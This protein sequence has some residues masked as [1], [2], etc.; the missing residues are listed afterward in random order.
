MLEQMRR[1]TSGAVMMFRT[2][3][4]ALNALNIFPMMWKIGAPQ[5]VKA[6]VNFGLGFYKGTDTY[7][8]NRA[9][10]MEHSP[11]M[12]S[13]MN[14]MDR[15]IQQDMKISVQAN[16][17]LAKEKARSVKDA[18]NR[19]GY[20]F[21][22]ETDLMMS[23]ALWKHSYDESMQKQVEAGELNRDVLERNAVSAADANVRAVYGSGM[24]KDQA[25]VQ[26]KN[27]LIGQLTPFYSYCNTQL[28]ALIAAGYNWKDNGNRMAVYNAALYWIVLPTIFESLYRSAVAGEVDDPDKMLRR[29]GLTAIR[30]ADQGI[31][32]ARDAIEGAVSVML[33]GY[34]GN[35]ITPLAV[36]GF[37]EMIN[38]VEA[39]TSDRKDWTDIGRAV[40]RVSNRYVGFSDTLTDGFWTLVR[41][42]LVDT[43]RNLMDLMTSIIFDKR[44]KT[45]EERKNMEK[46]KNKKGDN[47]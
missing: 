15:D 21:I 24:V 25:E 38:A 6:L 3:T 27:S 37:E 1:N 36:S 35:G 5:A 9:F 40:S 10:V 29:L 32:V 19:Y 47:K 7:N 12:R 18:V 26:R 31:P 28:N 16:T 2:T 11:M 14:T 33:E 4:A 17:G 42:S 43:D 45:V 8:A 30:N 20:W 13:R 46:R 39:A 22:T 44:Y 34:K 23:M 41:F